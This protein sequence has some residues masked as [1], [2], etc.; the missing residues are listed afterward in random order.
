[1]IAGIADGHATVTATLKAGTAVVAVA[2]MAVIV[3][4]VAENQIR[5][6]TKSTVLNMEIGAGLTVEAALQGAG[7]SPTDG[8]DIAWKS[9]D[10]NTVGLLSTEQNITRGNS[11]Y[12][13]AKSAGEAVLTLTH[14]KCEDTLE[15]WVLIPQRNEVS[16]TLDRTYL[17]LYKDDGAVAVTA[18][19]AGGSPADYASITWTAPKVSGQVIVSVSKATGKTCNIVPRNVGNTTLRAQLPNGKYAD[20]IVSVSS[21]AEIAP[22]TLAVHVNPGYT[23]TLSYKTNPEAAQVSWIAQSNSAADASEYFTFQVNEAAKTISVTGVKLGN[24]VL[25]GFFVGTSGGTTTRIQVYVEYTYE[26]ELKTSG[27][28]TKEPRNGNTITIPFR[29]FPTD[30]EIT[31]RVSDPGKLEVKSVSLNTLTGEGAVVLTPL[32][33]KKGL[34]VTL[35]AVNPKDPVNTPIIRTQYLDLRYEH[36][37][38]T[39]VF[40]FDAGSFSYYDAKTNTLYLGDGE[41]SLFH[42]NI[43]EEN[44][45]LENLQVF[46]QSV[47]GS[48]ADNKEVKNGGHI[49]LA[50]ESGASDS[51]EPLWRIGHNLDHLSTSP[52]FLISKDLYYTVFAQKYTYITVTDPPTEGRPFGGSHVERTTSVTE[53]TT[54]S[55]AQGQGIT[56]WWVD[57]H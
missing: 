30:L 29:V 21:A 13:T 17:E 57:V 33:E 14:P 27:I 18:T 3:S 24:G 56:G 32:G 8:Y 23:Q 45:E 19:L 4:P 20:C 41:Q 43:L 10:S 37:T 50:K 39:P 22:E 44:A 40:D 2:E 35:H 38:I 26:F 6:T 7:L 49:S 9:S 55:A 47:N 34:S 31:A 46:W 52:F 53:N 51:G 54:Y 28:I 42:L 1:M 16:I 5:I 48:A 15:I 11:A 25:N 36:L 12:I